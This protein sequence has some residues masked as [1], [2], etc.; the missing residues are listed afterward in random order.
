MG[1]KIRH[2]KNGRLT[3][4]GSFSRSHIYR[5]LANPIYIGKL[6]HKRQLHDGKHQAI[7]ELG[8]WE[9]AQAQL[10]RNKRGTERPSAKH[11]NLLAGRLEI[12]DGQKLLPSHA[13][14]QGERYRYYIEQRLVQD[15]DV[16]TKGARHAAAEVEKA[17]YD[18]AAV[19]G[20]RG[21]HR[22]SAGD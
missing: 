16:R 2:Q 8:L 9:R 12:F 3:G 7:M 4:G 1:S 22:R 10:R 5:L 6:P 11:S 17:A 14:K 13:V 20:R 21:R 19:P 18:T 15:E